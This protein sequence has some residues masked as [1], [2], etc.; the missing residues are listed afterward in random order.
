MRPW[1]RVAW[2]GS[3]WISR[4]LREPAVVTS[5]HPRVRGACSSET[6]GTETAEVEVPWL[7]GH[8]GGRSKA[9]ECR[10]VAVEGAPKALVV[11]TAEDGRG[12]AGIPEALVVGTTE[13]PRPESPEV[14]AKTAEAP[15]AVTETLE[16]VDTGIPKPS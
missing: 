2:P 8:L 7:G 16:A 12:V 15:P 13:G 3:L 5:L 11:G 10:G 14:L 4:G 1:V 6:C 9:E